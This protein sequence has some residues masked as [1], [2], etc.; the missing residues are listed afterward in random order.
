[1]TTIARHSDDDRLGEKESSPFRSSQPSKRYI[2]A[3]EMKQKRQAELD[4]LTALLERTHDQR[5]LRILSQRI[6]ATRNNLRSW[7]DYL[8]GTNE[9][10]KP[11][12]RES[13]AVIT[14]RARRASATRKAA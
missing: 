8:E 4:D 12:Y 5:T 10:Q 9:Q 13:K 3:L 2:A 7:V 6:L 11:C 1:M 14:P